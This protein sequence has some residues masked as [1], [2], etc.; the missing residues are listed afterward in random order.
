MKVVTLDT[1]FPEVHVQRT[2]FQDR[3]EEWGDGFPMVSFRERK[4]MSPTLVASLCLLST[5]SDW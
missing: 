3:T 1:D 4:L 5:E 2:D